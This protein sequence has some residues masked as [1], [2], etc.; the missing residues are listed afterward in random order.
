AAA[1]ATGGRWLE[2]PPGLVR[3][4][5]CVP[6]GLLPGPDC[7]RVV[8]ELFVQGTQPVEHEQFYQRAESGALVAQVQGEALRWA[9]DAG[10]T[11]RTA[12]DQQPQL[13]IQQPS[14]GAVFV[15][16]PELADQR[17]L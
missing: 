12:P 11:A 17:V 2:Q 15:I 10:L 9:L 3:Q 13:F 1:R 7:P 4:A 8:Q 5:V 6:T 16:A 14:D